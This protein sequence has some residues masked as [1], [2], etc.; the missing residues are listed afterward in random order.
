MERKLTDKE[1]AEI[2]R[3]AYQRAIGLLTCDD[4]QDEDTFRNGT[5]Y[6]MK[7]RD[8]LERKYGLEP[9]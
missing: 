1:R 4:D 7:A 3:D 2:R 8:A 9:R 6:L 5:H